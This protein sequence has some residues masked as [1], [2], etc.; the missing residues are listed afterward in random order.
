M[1]DVD[2]IPCVGADPLD[3]LLAVAR[4]AVIHAIA[5][6]LRTRARHPAPGGRDEIDRIVER[7]LPSFPWLGGARVAIERAAAATA[8]AAGDAGDRKKAAGENGSRTEG[9][10]R[11]RKR[12]RRG[13]DPGGATAKAKKGADDVEGAGENADR[14]EGSKREEARDRSK[15]D[16]ADL[17]VASSGEGGPALGGT[18]ARGASEPSND[19][20]GGP[21]PESGGP[22]PKSPRA[23]PVRVPWSERI[24]AC[25]TYYSKHGNLD[26]KPK[27]PDLGH[28]CRW[29]RVMRVSAAVLEKGGKSTNGLN[30]SRLAELR[31]VGFLTTAE[32]RANRFRRM[33]A[34]LEK[35]KAERGHCNIP[36]SDTS[37]L[38]KWVKYTRHEYS[39][40]LRG[41]QSPL[42]SME[43]AK[44]TEIGVV[45]PQTTMGKRRTWE[46]WM[47]LCRSFLAEN[48]HLKI[49]RSH[50][51]LGDFCGRVRNAYKVRQEG[52]QSTYL[53]DERE[54]ELDDMGFVWQVG[55]RLKSQL[56]PDGRRLT[57]TFDE[58]FELLLEF[59][60][61]HGHV[62]VPQ[63]HPGGLGAWV[64]H[65][66]AGAKCLR[67]GQG[68][69]RGMT[70]ERY[71]RLADVGF[72]F[73]VTNLRGRRT[74]PG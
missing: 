60:E 55:V 30:P 66:R 57:R 62:V 8:T 41:E 29:L 4:S 34:E 39:R 45:L 35:Y 14:D 15:D 64:A 38:G 73:D 59:R 11:G 43:I 27:D 37:E 56:G 23:E 54:R 51:T 21:E 58:W 61:E 9:T 50:P 28:Y 7:L 10:R 3:R 17:D 18:S 40:L 70:H 12:K 42:T 53:T 74:S 6:H 49:P 26:I 13:P 65:M 25:R 44:L 19:R 22:A 16:N 33:F 32:R 71:M 5:F 47:E 36:S 68:I 48:G 46:E 20:G 52:R 67:T 1:A 2:S 69:L 72:M 63:H 24:A 31:G